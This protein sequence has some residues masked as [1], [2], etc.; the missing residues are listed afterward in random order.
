MNAPS[1]CPDGVSVVDRVPPQLYIVGSGLIQ[2]VGAAL[3]VVA[4]ASVEP[5]SV[6]WWRVLTGAVVLLAWKRPWRGGLT[7]SDLAISALFGVIILTMNSSFYESIARIPLG[8]AVSL[9]FIG[10]VAVA[11]LRGRGWR[12][13]IAAVLAFAGVACIGGLALDLSV[14]SVRVGVAWILLAALAWSAYIVVGQR[15][16]TTRDGVTNLA[17]G[18][19]W[20][21]LFFAPFLGPGAMAAT[22]SWEL[23]AIVVG[24]GLLSTAIPY[25]LFAAILP[26]TS[27]LVG[28]VML[29]Q[30]PG[31]YELIGLVLVSI[32]VWLASR[33]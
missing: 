12:P 7:V 4:F 20:G 5:A 15:A 27:A 14:P 2:Y 33:Q 16:S 10:P 9:E 30:I 6:A 1:R 11:V 32:A 21:S 25:A 23:I 8:T 18:C 3:A 26:A 13:R 19:A 22:A 31:V 29:R 28:A 24:V 17:L